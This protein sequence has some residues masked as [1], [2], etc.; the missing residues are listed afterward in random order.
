M[1]GRKTRFMTQTTYNARLQHMIDN[2]SDKLKPIEEGEN[3]EIQSVTG[4]VIPGHTETES[5]S[6]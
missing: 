2:N 5:N 4:S 6:G 1:F 3:L